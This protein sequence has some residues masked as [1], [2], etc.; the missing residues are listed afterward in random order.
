MTKNPLCRFCTRW[1]SQCWNFI[2]GIMKLHVWGKREPSCKKEVLPKRTQET[3][4][5]NQNLMKMQYI[6]V[7]FTRLKDWMVSH[8]AARSIIASDKGA[9]ICVFHMTWMHQ[10]ESVSF[11]LLMAHFPHSWPD[12]NSWNK[13]DPLHI[14][15][16]L[17]FWTISFLHKTFYDTLLE[18]IHCQAAV[19]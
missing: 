3:N 5:M 17:E 8:I 7:V 6:E 4:T 16:S 18:E 11:V 9:Y 2:T 15:I 10:T 1:V 13:I 14:S 12:L 19:P